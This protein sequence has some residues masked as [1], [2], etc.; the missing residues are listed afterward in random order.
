MVAPIGPGDWV[1]CIST[2]G[3]D[4][5]GNRIY[6]GNVYCVERIESFNDIPGSPDGD[7]VK[8]VDVGDQDC[9]WKPERFRPLGGNTNTRT[10][11]APPINAPAR[12]S[13]DA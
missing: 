2:A 13:E 6:A 8:L 1:Q 10:L 3:P 4:S 11:R 5:Y 9:L 7:G 12:E